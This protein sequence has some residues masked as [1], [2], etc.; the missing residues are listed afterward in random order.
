MA[1]DTLDVNDTAKQLLGKLRIAI[2][3]WKADRSK[4]IDNEVRFLKSLDTSVS[5]AANSAL[6]EAANE[7]S[8]ILTELLDYSPSVADQE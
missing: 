1:E 5:V 4:E 2:A 8:Q 7:A 3:D 6:L